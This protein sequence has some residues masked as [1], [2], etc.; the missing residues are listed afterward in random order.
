MVGFFVRNVY[1]GNDFV[2]QALKHNSG[3][4]FVVV[5][6]GGRGGLQGLNQI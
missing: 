1:L 2:L 5:E 4:L 6:L 3:W